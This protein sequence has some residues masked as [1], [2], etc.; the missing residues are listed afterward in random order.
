MTAG[1]VRD[2]VIDKEIYNVVMID[3]IAYMH[4]QAVCITYNLYVS[5]CRLWP[6]D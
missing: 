4:H 3:R 2:I 6:Y 1:L 5:H